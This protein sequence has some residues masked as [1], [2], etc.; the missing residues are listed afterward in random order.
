MGRAGGAGALG[1]EV[2]VCDSSLCLLPC[3]YHP[4]SAL[5]FTKAEP[6]E[7]DNQ[8]R[9]LCPAHRVK[10]R[11]TALTHLT[12]IRDEALR[13]TYCGVLRER[14]ERVW[15]RVWCVPGPR[16]LFQSRVI[17]RPSSRAPSQ[18]LPSS[19]VSMSVSLSLES[20]RTHPVSCM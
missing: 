12:T 14:R 3:D 13:P 10:T 16:F 20:H 5:G 7:G 11:A 15:L 1:G 19:S 4:C 18:H 8:G 2:C 17:G 6:R 9:S